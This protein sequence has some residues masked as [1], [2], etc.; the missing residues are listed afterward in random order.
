VVT[1]RPDGALQLT[2]GGVYSFYETINTTGRAIPDSV[3]RDQVDA[4][5]L[6]PRPDW[7]DS[8]YVP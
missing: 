3:W 4:G 8:F 5:D 1:D 6:P 7:I 2:R